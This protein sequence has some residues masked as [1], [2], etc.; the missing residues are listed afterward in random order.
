MKRSV[1]ALALL[2]FATSC[3]AVSDP[4]Q[5][6]QCAGVQDVRSS[7]PSMVFIPGGITTIGSDRFH[8]EEAPQRRVRVEGFW[9]D[10]HEVT[11]REFADFVRATGYVT[12]NEKLG[13]GA[14]FRQPTEVVDWQDISQWWRLEQTAS[15]RFPHGKKGSPAVDHQPVVQVTLDDALAFAKWR[16]G[17]LPTEAEWER[18][19][20]GGL[21]RSE[22]TWGDEPEGER[23][24]ANHWEGIFPVKDTGADGYKGLAPVGCF[25]ICPLLSGPISILELATK[26]EWNGEEA[27]AGRDHRQA[28]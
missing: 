6:M 25:L 16:G 11:N 26:E 3:S 13:G 20:R 19:A 9:I 12:T 10:R 22:Y 21:D 8:A 7:R 15:W 14:V 18:A 2:G 5:P 28:A 4:T 17:D 23:P 1:L 27:Q 24:L